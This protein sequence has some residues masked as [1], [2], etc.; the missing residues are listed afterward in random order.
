MTRLFYVTLKVYESGLF[1]CLWKILQSGLKNR[2]NAYSVDIFHSIEHS[3]LLDALQPPQDVQVILLKFFLETLQNFFDFCD[4]LA[5]QF[6]FWNVL[7][8]EFLADSQITVGIVELH[9]SSSFKV[10]GLQRRP[11]PTALIV[12]YSSGSQHTKS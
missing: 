8:L 2:E 1:D 11:L 12:E 10:S 6:S 3:P 7:G 5:T 9:Q 4:E